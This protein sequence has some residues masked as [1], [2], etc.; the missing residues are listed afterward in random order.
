MAQIKITLTKSPIGRLPAQRATSLT[1]PRFPAKVSWR[2]VKVI[3]IG[4]T[5]IGEIYNEIK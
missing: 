3:S 2:L 4:V 5:I 1:L